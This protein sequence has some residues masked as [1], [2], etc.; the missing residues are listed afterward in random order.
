[1]FGDKNWRKGSSQIKM[2]INKLMVSLISSNCFLIFG[3]VFSC[4]YKLYQV[5]I[6][7]IIGTVL[8][9]ALLIPFIVIFKKQYKQAVE[10][11]Q[12]NLLNRD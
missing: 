6:P 1:M 10:E 4:I 7:V 3:L 12:K 9:N 5:L 2:T 8:M 11:E